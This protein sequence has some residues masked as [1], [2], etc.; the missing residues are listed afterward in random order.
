MVVACG[1]VPSLLVCACCGGSH[2]VGVGSYASELFVV[3]ALG[4]TFGVATYV[5]FVCCGL[6]RTRY[7][8]SLHADAHEFYS[9]VGFVVH[10]HD[11]ED[12]SGDDDAGVSG[13]GTTHPPLDG[14]HGSTYADR[15]GEVAPT[16]CCGRT[17]ACIDGLDAALRV[18]MGLPPR[19][20]RRRQQRAPSEA[21]ALEGVLVA[22][23]GSNRCDA[24]GAGSGAATASEPLLREHRAGVGPSRG[25]AAP[26]GDA[27][28]SGTDA[29]VHKLQL[30]T[31]AEAKAS[32][33]L[34]KRRRRK[35]LAPPGDAH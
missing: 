34:Q 21:P 6:R 7:C 24:A 16:G 32:A 20:T 4:N 10:T 18:S 11:S 13:G 5:A 15:A 29:S 3:C 22:S 9:R 35:Q 26:A 28:S 2:Q 1:V 23:H 33:S 17:S 30:R 19:H 25:S 12:D 27:A 14:T 31:L 8:K